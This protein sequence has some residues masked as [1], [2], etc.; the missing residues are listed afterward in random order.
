MSRVTGTAL[1]CLLG[2]SLTGC[3]EPA[4]HD[5]TLVGQRPAKAQEAGNTLQNAESVCK[6]DTKRK[7]MANILAIFSRFRQG[8][9]DKDYI[10]CMKARGYEVTQ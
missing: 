10:A 8:A 3:A 6:E 2:A 1:A 4:P 9:A 5:F 7:G